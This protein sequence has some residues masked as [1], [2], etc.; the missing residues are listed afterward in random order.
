MWFVDALK[1][2]LSKGESTRLGS[3][4]VGC[5]LQGWGGWRGSCP[6]APVENMIMLKNLFAKS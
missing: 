3:K 4:Y 1:E 6:H 5:N 2:F